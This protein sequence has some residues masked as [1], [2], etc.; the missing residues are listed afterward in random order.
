MTEP[1]SGGE[2]QRFIGL[3]LAAIGALW[4]AFSGLCAAGMIYSMIAE[5]ASHPELLVWAF[6]VVI[7]SGISG[8]MG[9]GVFVV[10]RGLWVRK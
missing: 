1:A 10:G 6:G 8:A 5:G 7:I 9:Y 4:I 2:V 3:A